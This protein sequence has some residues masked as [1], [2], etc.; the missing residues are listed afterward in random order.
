[1]PLHFADL[2][3]RLDGAS[4][5]A[6]LQGAMARST[7]ELGYS[8]FTYLL[9]RRPD[10]PD[11]TYY[12]STYPKTWTDHYEERRY[13][14]SDPVMLDARVAMLPFQWLG[15]SIRRRARGLQRR[16]LDEAGDFAI[17]DGM[18]IPI[19]GPGGEF[20]VMSA[21]PSGG[22]AFDRLFTESRDCMHLLAL[23]CHA[24]VGRLLDPP[25]AK[26]IRLSPRE[27]ECLLWTARGKTAWETG[28]IL[29]LSQG[30]VAWHLNNAKAKLGVYGKS[31]AVVKALMLGLIAL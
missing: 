20:A 8:H 23:H 5:L 27:R 1:M 6:E 26:P 13:V 2:R 12:F 17:R 16:I 9:V 11:A 21:T 29:K 24:T 31:H 15:E 25:D 19:H 10:L 14:R 30:T 18:T 4:D 28:E 22:G 3:E 7:D